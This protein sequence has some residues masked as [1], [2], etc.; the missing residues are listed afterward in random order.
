VPALSLASG[1]A[2]G[3]VVVVVT[4]NSKYNAGQL[5]I[6][7]EGALVAQVPLTADLLASG[8]N[9]SATVPA[10]TA[11]SLYYVSVRVWN[12]S[13]PAQNPAPPG[14][15]LTAGTLSRQWFDTPADLRSTTSVS[16]PITIN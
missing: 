1:A 16:L 10:G 9:V 2:T 7:H 12:T 15:G 11:S 3:S 4:A 6:S 14:T 8:G 5:L 13:N